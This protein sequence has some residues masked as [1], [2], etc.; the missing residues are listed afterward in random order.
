MLSIYKFYSEIDS[1]QERSE[2]KDEANEYLDEYFFHCIK[3]TLGI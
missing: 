3:L 1:Y 2:I